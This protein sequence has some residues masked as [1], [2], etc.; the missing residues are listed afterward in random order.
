MTEK[1]E[2]AQGS[3]LSD[4]LGALSEAADG[5]DWG[6]PSAAWAPCFHLDR[7]SRFC[8]RASWWFGHGPM[9]DYVSL[10]DLFDSLKP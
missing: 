1:N 8:G 3:E 6:Q 7:D 9:H 10:A 4:R 2:Q 5:F